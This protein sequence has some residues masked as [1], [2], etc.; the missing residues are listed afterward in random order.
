MTGKHA[1]PFVMSIKELT[2]KRFTKMLVKICPEVSAKTDAFCQL[3]NDHKNRHA[4]YSHSLDN[5][6]F[7]GA[8]RG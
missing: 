5:V 3:K 8:H 6:H 2:A 7:W 1:K 4:G